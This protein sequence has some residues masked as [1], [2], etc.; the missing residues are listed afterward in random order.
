MISAKYQPGNSAW[1]QGKASVFEN[2]RLISLTTL[3]LPGKLSFTGSAIL[4]QIEAVILRE[5]LVALR[6]ST[7]P[8]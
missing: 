3:Q 2:T 1:D 8:A 4:G 6:S 5:P 7:C